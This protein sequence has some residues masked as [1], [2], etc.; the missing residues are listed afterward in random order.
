MTKEELKQMSDKIIESAEYDKKIKSEFNNYW[1]TKFFKFALV[2]IGY[3]LFFFIL[4]N[5]CEYETVSI[6]GYITAFVLDIPM[7]FLLLISMKVETPLLSN[8]KKCFT[9]VGCAFKLLCRLC[10]FSPF[11]YMLYGILYDSSTGRC[12]YPIWKIILYAPIVFVVLLVGSLIMNTP[13]PYS[14]KIDGNGNAVM[15]KYDYHMMRRSQ[16]LAGID[17]DKMPVMLSANEIKN[18]SKTDWFELGMELEIAGYKVF[19]K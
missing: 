7:T 10:A 6:W 9:V 19:K 14:N 11:V 13:A 5:T 3:F 4:Q 1:I 15:T 12:D 17:P 16:E 18:M 8:G 2:P